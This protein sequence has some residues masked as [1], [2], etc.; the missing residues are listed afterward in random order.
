M[1]SGE[2]RIGSD[3]LLDGSRTSE[4]S[5]LAFQLC[6]HISK[7]QCTCWL[8]ASLT[9]S[10]P[11]AGQ[12]RVHARTCRPVSPF[13]KARAKQCTCS[14][15]I[16]CKSSA[17]CAKVDHSLYFILAVCL[18]AMPNDDISHINVDTESEASRPQMGAIQAVADLARLSYAAARALQRSS[19]SSSPLP[20]NPTPRSAC[21]S[22]P[23]VLHV[24]PFTF[25]AIDKPGQ[26]SSAPSI[27]SSTI[28]P[29]TQMATTKPLEAVSVGRF[30][31]VSPN[32]PAE[33]EPPRR[34]L[35]ASVVPSSRMARMMHY[36]GMQ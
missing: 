29:A 31:I 15:S 19:R 6:I 16:D 18:Q 33:D 23:A 25:C 20:D 7:R 12:K 9:T 2:R 1:L 24:W 28:V 13:G 5:R 34:A 17:A 8:F 26:P 3:I 30:D 21:Q 10:R 27:G 11:R 32:Q 14:P 36:G 4:S 35:K 22:L